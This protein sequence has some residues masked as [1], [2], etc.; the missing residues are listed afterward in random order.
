M[1]VVIDRFE[2]PWSFLSNFA[3]PLISFE[4]QRVAVEHA[5]QASKTLDPKWRERILL[6]PTPGKA[7]R[8]GR[9]APLRPDWET[10]KVEVMSALVE[11]KFES[12][13][14]RKLLLSTN[15][16]LIEEGNSWHDTFWGVC[17]GCYRG[18]THNG[19]N[20]PGLILMQARRRL[21]RS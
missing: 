16:T 21:L 7:K 15:G 19:Q 5:F 9:L 20:E 4:G 13:E 11:T 2:G 14:G 1:I 12:T 18:C 8:L 6:A 10:L 3:P 17:T